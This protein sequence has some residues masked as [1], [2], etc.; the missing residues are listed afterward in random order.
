MSRR[1]GSRSVALIAIVFVTGL[2]VAACGGHRK[3]TSLVAVE[4]TTTTGSTVV[5]TTTEPVTTTSSTTAGSPTTTTT[6]TV[7]PT[8]TTSKAVVTTAPATTASTVSRSGGCPADEVPRIVFVRYGPNGGPP[9]HL[10]SVKPDGTC[11][12]QLTFD[13]GNP[14]VLNWGPSWSPQRDRI[15]FVRKDVGLMVMDA[16]GHN[17]RVLLPETQPQ[18]S[19]AWTSW[20]PDGTSIA[21]AG[22]VDG[23]LVVD[24]RTGSDRKVADE[25]GH[26]VAT[27]TW[28]PDGVSIAYSV[29]RD[30]GR[31][32]IVTI[33]ADGSGPKTIGQGFG[34]DWG[35]DGRI[36]FGP[37]GGGVAVMNAD[38]SGVDQLL[39]DPTAGGAQWSP[40]QT[41]LV[42]GR[43]GGEI[44]VM[45]ADGNA[46]HPLLQAHG[47]DTQP[48]W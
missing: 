42:F 21:F 47:Y 27:P 12:T 7:R 46:M 15:A 4:E 2:C 16:D 36:A 37:K 33:R 30:P 26:I 34:P 22:R 6:T 3:Q 19:G 20:S 29:D 39:D 48:D 28:S 8:T 44:A 32:D 40:D 17:E 38:G 10:F 45:N 14:S 1:S 41:Q 11:L 23:L 13:N 43:N 35:S 31:M 5:V 18:T 24:S 9:R 25:R